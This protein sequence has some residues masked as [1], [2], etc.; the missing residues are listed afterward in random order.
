VFVLRCWAQSRFAHNICF[1]FFSARCGNSFSA[2]GLAL[3]HGTAARP[4]SLFI[5]RRPMLLP[6][7]VQI[8]SLAGRQEGLCS[9]RSIGHTGSSF[10]SGP[11]LPVSEGRPFNNMTLQI[12][13]RLVEPT[14]ADKI[15]RTIDA[16]FSSLPARTKNRKS[17]SRL[18]VQQP[19]RQLSGQNSSR[20][21]LLSHNLTD[22]H[23]V[24]VSG[25]SPASTATPVR[26]SSIPILPGFYFF[27]GHNLSRMTPSLSSGLWIP[28]CGG[29][30][31]GCVV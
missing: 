20:Q 27:R 31:G 21:H 2:S 9:S 12:Q 23:G 15:A 26:S 8:P 17:R 1:R 13:H 30:T 11:R 22:L 19:L 16:P 3:L 29:R 10:L 4:V 14:P 25:S 5:T 6:I 24:A 7:C 18:Q 28:S